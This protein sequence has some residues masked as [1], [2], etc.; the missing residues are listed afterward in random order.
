MWN[1]FRGKFWRFV[2]W[3]A[4]YPVFFIRDAGGRS[5]SHKIFNC[6]SPEKFIWRNEGM[7]MPRKVCWWFRVPRKWV[8]CE[9]DA[10]QEGLK[11]NNT[12]TAEFCN[13]CPE[14]RF[15]YFYMK[16]LYL[17]P[18]MSSLDATKD[19]YI[20]TLLL[21]SLKLKSTDRHNKQK[22]LGA[23]DIRRG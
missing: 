10:N 1:P 22:I 23:P 15:R 16:L 12:V 20:G 13:V 18:E 3:N 11:S 21:A 14:W 2:P 4:S 7:H 9:S 5:V 19:R 6:A 8:G 17:L